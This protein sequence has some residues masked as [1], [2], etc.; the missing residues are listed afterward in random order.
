MAVRA[1]DSGTGAEHPMITQTD[2]LMGRESEYPLDY[3]L[4]ANLLDLFE[5]ANMMFA[6]YR[7]DTGRELKVSSGYRPGHYNTEAG[8]AKHSPHLYCMAID[9]VDSDGAVDAWVQ[10]NLE[11]IREFGFVGVEHP[12][13]TPGWC[14]VDMVQRYDQH[15][16]AFQ[17][18]RVR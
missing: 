12:K 1:L 18:F 15:G 8:G 17:V 16:N 9:W 7:S 4:E 6:A 10:A 14:H 2:I 5:A 13:D 11:R 3:K